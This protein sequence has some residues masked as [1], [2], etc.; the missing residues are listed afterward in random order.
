MDELISLMNHPHSIGRNELG[1]VG[2][3]AA[4][5]FLSM[6]VGMLDKRYFYYTCFF[7]YL[8]VI[9]PYNNIADK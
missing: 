7:Y 9:L 8:M 6:W 1:Q 5:S 3:E 4:L 2:N